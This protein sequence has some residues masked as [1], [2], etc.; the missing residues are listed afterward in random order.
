MP[1]TYAW[2]T[3]AEW[4]RKYGPLTYLNIAGQPILVINS[5]ETATD[6][7]EKTTYSGRP[8]FVMSSELCGV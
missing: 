1:Q 7:L 4:G 8:R 5:H 6:L 3:F 2:C